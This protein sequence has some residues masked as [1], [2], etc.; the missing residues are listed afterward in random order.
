MA[1]ASFE[2]KTTPIPLD[3]NS[4]SGGYV[5]KGR[6]YQMSAPGAKSVWRVRFSGGTVRLTF[7]KPTAATLVDVKGNPL[8]RNL[9]TLNSVSEK[10]VDITILA[11]S[12]PA[13]VLLVAEDARGKNLDTLT[14]SI[15]SLVS[16]TYMI[17]LLHNPTMRTTRKGHEIETMMSKVAATYL[18][19]AN[20]HLTESAAVNEKLLISNDFALNEIINLTLRKPKFGVKGQTVTFHEDVVDTLNRDSLFGK[21]DFHMVST[22]QMRGPLGVTPGFGNICYVANAVNPGAELA[23]TSTWAHELGHAFKLDHPDHAINELMAAGNVISRM[24]SFIM[25]ADDID[26]IN[27]SGR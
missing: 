6:K 27:P 26:I 24:D 3:V 11:G 18:A 9:L 1:T 23:E 14:L 25:T 8:P 12:S 21:A 10:T 4:L 7:D 17:H 20:V 16:K 2:L 13:R 19:Q 22:T 5:G 15:K